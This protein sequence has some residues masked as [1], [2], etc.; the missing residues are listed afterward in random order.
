MRSISSYGAKQ[1]TLD[2]ASDIDKA[3]YITAQKTP[4]KRDA[5]YVK[6]VSD[7][8]GMSESQVRA[9]GAMVRDAIKEQARSASPGT[10]DIPVVAQQPPPSQAGVLPA[11]L[12]SRDVKSQLADEAIKAKRPSFVHEGETYHQVAGGT[13][14]KP[15]FKAQDEL[16]PGDW[17]ADAATYKRVWGR[18]MREAQQLMKAWQ[19]DWNA[20]TRMKNPVQKSERMEFLN[21]E[22]EGI[23][24]GPRGQQENAA[25]AWHGESGAISTEL[26]GVDKLVQGIRNATESGDALSTTL[27][28]FLRPASDVLRRSSSKAANAVEDLIFKAEIDKGR[29][30]AEYIKRISSA[31]SEVNRIPGQRRDHLKSAVMYVLDS[32]R[33][34]QTG[35]PRKGL[36]TKDLDLMAENMVGNVYK[37]TSREKDIVIT[38]AR[39]LRSGVFE[40]LIKRAQDLAAAGEIK[41]AGYINGYFPH[42]M[43]KMEAEVGETVLREYFGDGLMSRYLKTR[44]SRLFD[45]TGVSLDEVLGSYTR[46]MLRT[47]HD[48]PAVNLARRYANDIDA[49]TLRTTANW[50][51]DNYTG[52]QSGVNKALEELGKTGQVV[53]NF[54]RGVAKMWYDNLIGLNPKTWLINPSQILVNTYPLLGEK[55]LIKGFAGFLRPGSREILRREGIIEP[56]NM[57]DVDAISKLR[58]GYHIGMKGTEV[59]NRGVSYFGALSKGKAMGLRG[60]ELNYYAHRIVQDTQF[61]YNRAGDIRAIRSLTPDMRVFKQYMAKEVNFIGNRFMDAFHAARRQ[62]VASKEFRQSMLTLGRMGF[63]WYLTYKIFGESIKDVFMKGFGGYNRQGIGSHILGPTGAAVKDTSDAISD[64]IA[65]AIEGD[66]TYEDIGENLYNAVLRTAPTGLS[67][68]RYVLNDNVEEEVRKI[69]PGAWQL[70]DA[71]EPESSGGGGRPERSDRPERPSR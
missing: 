20:A 12:R 29:D 39:R 58:S 53:Q 11:I 49:P 41:K 65:D 42:Q 16:L 71:M 14:A 48:Q 24:W 67:A 6:F 66:L 38:A 10:L 3:A 30:V 22:F 9:H 61:N 23:F 19:K 18:D 1:F 52:K 51:I 25:S 62:G 17:L 21:K 15:V 27:Q 7:A 33:T 13:K 69:L 54:S 44:Q 8:T 46:S 64:M 43:K 70:F 36:E 45:L 68:K 5:D 37:L 32:G 2:F 26:L 59:L 35:K 28:S 50:Y 47:I 60:K 40:S 57:F 31:L 4:S 63:A 55:H 56:S 34:A